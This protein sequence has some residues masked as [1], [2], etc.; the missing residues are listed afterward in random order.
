MECSNTHNN[1][2]KEGK[3]GVLMVVVVVVGKVVPSLSI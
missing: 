2:E 1:V 3:S